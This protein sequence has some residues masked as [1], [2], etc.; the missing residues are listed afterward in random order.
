MLG[1][2][3]LGM[4]GG[5]RFPT[6]E[7]NFVC[8]NSDGS[9]TTTSSTNSCFTDILKNPQVQLISHKVA[10]ANVTDQT[11]DMLTNKDKATEDEKVAIKEWSR[12]IDDCRKKE[13]KQ[14]SFQTMPPTLYALYRSG[15]TAMDNSR[16]MLYNGEITYGQFAQIRKNV[17]DNGEMASAQIKMELAKQSADSEARAQQL[18]LQAE[19]VNLAAIQTHMMGVQTMNQTRMVNNQTQ[20]INQQQQQ[21]F[22]NQNRT[23]VTNCTD[24]GTSVNCTSTTR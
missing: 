8:L 12:L 23:R 22:Y 20:L 10:L 16:V 13:S 1:A 24:L 19:Q 5:P 15:Q 18:A 14:Y 21:M 3:P 4:P 2:I 17:A 9:T 6:A 7:L 11:F